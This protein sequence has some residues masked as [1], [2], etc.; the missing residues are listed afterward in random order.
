MSGARQYMSVGC[1]VAWSTSSAGGVVNFLTHVVFVWVALGLRF[2]HD[3]GFVSFGWG[4]GGL[5]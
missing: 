3:W 5:T 2:C 4:I 1:C